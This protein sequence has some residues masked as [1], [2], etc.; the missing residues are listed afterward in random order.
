MR[1][2]SH[3]TN[4]PLAVTCLALLL[5]CFTVL[6]PDAIAASN[7]KAKSDT[8]GAEII[9]EV[10]EAPVGGDFSLNSATGKFSL[11]DLRGTAVLLSFGFTHCPDVCPTSLSFLSS[12]LDNLDQPTLARVR[13][14]FVTLDPKRDSIAQLDEYARYF[15]DSI[16]GL[17]GT[18]NEIEQVAGQYGVRYAE[19]KLEGSSIEY[20][21]NHS[22]ATY[23][24]NPN[25][26][27][28]FIFPH[29]TP[30]EVVAEAV[31]SVLSNSE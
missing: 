20:T 10:E 14:L 8:V 13:G 28:Q 15:H 5:S 11:S 6:A 12:A 18:P 2:L 29:M 27:L 4:N 23:L 25:G 31:E 24:I 21:I 26:D 16:S 17:T 22:A 19:V 3:G 9:P 30:P 7:A 1:T